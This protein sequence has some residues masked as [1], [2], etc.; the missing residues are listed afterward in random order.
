MQR[1]S[2]S[3]RYSGCD[4]HKRANQYDVTSPPR[5]KNIPV[6]TPT[7]DHRIG[8]GELLAHQKECREDSCHRDVANV[9]TAKSP[10]AAAI[11][12]GLVIAID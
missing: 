1:T 11:A 4:S 9:Q 7:P 10:K 8:G 6:A 5:K 12:R 3:S 2:V